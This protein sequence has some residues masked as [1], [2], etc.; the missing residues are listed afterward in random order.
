MLQDD[1]LPGL[2][3]DLVLGRPANCG[4][5]AGSG[6]KAFSAEA[7]VPNQAIAK[8]GVCAGIRPQSSIGGKVHGEKKTRHS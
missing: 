5:V 7:Q 4:L 8:S 6:S 1:S 2:L 3:F